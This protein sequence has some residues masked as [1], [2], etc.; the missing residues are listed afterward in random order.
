MSHSTSLP[1][2]CKNHIVTPVQTEVPPRWKHSPSDTKCFGRS[3]SL[4]LD[5]DSAA[6]SLS[7]LLDNNRSRSTEVVLAVK[8]RG[9]FLCGCIS[10]GLKKKK[11]K[12]RVALEGALTDRSQQNSRTRQP[13]AADSFKLD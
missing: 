2:A 12:Y 10:L 11:K 7:A 3:L 1:S 5:S 4:T 8:R 6:G 9:V 13:S